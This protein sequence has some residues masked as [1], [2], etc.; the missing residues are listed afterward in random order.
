MLAFLPFGDICVREELGQHRDIGQA[1]ERFVERP[2]VGRW[3]QQHT[4]GCK[5]D[6][7][8]AD[9]ESRECGRFRPSPPRHMPGIVQHLRREEFVD[10]VITA[11]PVLKLVKR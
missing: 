3:L 2:L 8:L 4:R 11:V 10:K 9:A 7:A 6:A 5:Q 1:E